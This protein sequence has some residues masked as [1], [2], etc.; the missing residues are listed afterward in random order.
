MQ[1]L[2]EPIR[3]E[4][5]RAL[6]QLP[7]E[8]QPNRKGL[9]ASDILRAH[10]LIANHFYIQD[11]GLGGVGP[12]SIDLL[13]SAVERQYVG[14]GAAAKWSN[15]FDVCAT[16]FFGLIK[17]HAF[18]DANKRT[19]FLSALYFLYDEGWVPSVPEK[20]FED[21]TVEISDNLLGKYARYKDFVKDGLG[22]PEVRFISHYL[23]SNTRRMDK[24]QYGIT[25]R[26]LKIILN[27]FGF[28]LKDPSGNH[29][30]I[31]K[32]EKKKTLLGFGPVRQVE[33]RVCQVGFPRW[34]AE[35][36][37]AALKT[38]REATK[39]S[40]KDGVDSAAFF[41]GLDP[42]Q[43]LIVTYNAPL[44]RLANR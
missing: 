3:R 17:N 32:P 2:E 35:V 13:V 7:P 12:R 40:A 4:F 29:I 15:I 6:V 36:G 34:T 30:N 37:K 19:A 28:D 42:M 9:N 41:R 26:E 44:L 8:T 25:F 33:T 39:L 20:D 27:R 43:S 18:H 22:D 23:R 5:E 21:F 31:V 10:F 11:E 24:A 16:L 1:F 38:I 14:Y